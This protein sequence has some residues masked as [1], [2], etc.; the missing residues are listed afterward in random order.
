MW[1]LPI[2]LL[3]FGL[4]GYAS[5]Q[6]ARITAEKSTIKGTVIDKYGA[7]IPNTKV[8]FIGRSGNTFATAT[9]RDGVFQI[10]VSDDT[11]RIEFFVEGFKPFEIEGYR[12]AFKSRMTLDVV[13]DVGIIID[14]ITI[15]SP[16]KQEKQILVTG[17]V[18][19]PGGAAIRGV[20]ITVRG[21]N[22]TSFITVTNVD[23]IYEM[24]LSP[25]VYSIELSSPGFKRA[26]LESFRVVNAP[27]GKIRHDV[28][29]E[30]GS[31]VNAPIVVSDTP[32]KTLR[33]ASP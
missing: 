17:T 26:V 4:F 14:T 6:D 25:G 15:P 2:L 24:R 20:N 1:V 22:N 21:D 7:V 12:V 23:G 5:A 11:Y 9:N 33:N 32:K 28:I 13:L 3:I 29:L 30:I 19:D 31:V 16:K 18:F 8:N 27:S 10:E